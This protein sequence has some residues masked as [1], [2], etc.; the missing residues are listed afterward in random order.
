MYVGAYRYATKSDK[1]AFVGNV[2]T[3]HPNLEMISSTYSR[4]IMAN[5]TYCPN[6]QQAASQAEPTCNKKAKPERL[7]KVM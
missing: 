4:A 3:R 2:L 6:R 5:N 7:K 1:K